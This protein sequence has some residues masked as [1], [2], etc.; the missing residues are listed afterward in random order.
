MELYR[1][2][3]ALPELENQK[4]RACIN[5]DR[6]VLNYKSL[7]RICGISQNSAG[8]GCTRAVCV[9]KADAYGHGADMCVSALCDAGCNFFAVSCIEEALAIRQLLNQKNNHSDILILGYTPPEYAALLSKHNVIQALL[10]FEYALT[11]EKK[12]KEAGV[13]VKAHAAIDTGMNRIGFTVNSESSLQTA[14]EQIKQFCLSENLQMS[15]MFTHFASADGEELVTMA[16]DSQTRNQAKLFIRLREKLRSDGISLFSHACNSAA[17]VRFPE[18]KLDGVRF[19]IMLYGYNPSGYINLPLL[20]VMRLETEICHIHTAKRG[21][22]VSY[23]GTYTAPK[24]IKIATLPIGYADGFIRKYSGCFVN[25]HI[26]DEVFKAPIIGRICMDQCMAD[27]TEIKNA[28]VGDRVVLFGDDPC[29]L[30]SLSDAA[31]TI[32]YESLCT[33]SSRVVRKY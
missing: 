28:S 5:L 9:V 1:N 6:L 12:A 16:E 26:G 2:Y 4:V 20:P 25:I 24:D 8:A 33:V 3:S 11:L 13:C 14:A 31:G 30:T 22:K 7:C 27:I 21:E 18:Y 23:G 10:S 19:G 29:Q 32:E 17:A 15:G